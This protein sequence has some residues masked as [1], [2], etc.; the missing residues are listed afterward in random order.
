MRTL[1]AS[2]I[3]ITALSSL[4]AQYLVSEILM[5]SPGWNTVLW[6]MAGY[7]TV[8][9]NIL[10][11]A[12][13]VAAALSPGRIA[14]A[15]SAG[16]TLWICAVGVVYHLVLA[17]LWKPEGL[18]WWADQ[19]LHT[20]VPIL[21]LIWWLT[22]ANKAGLQHRHAFLWLIWPAFYCVYALARGAVSGFYPY[23]F[24]DVANLG[25]G[26][27]AVSISGLLLA[28]FVGGLGQVALSRKI[29]SV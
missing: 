21:V 17:T 12:T 28:F 18:A 6:R 19:G 29:A 5:G 13:F 2:L 23:P 11:A 10:V 14:A 25:I 26:Q 15:W 4:M 24:I 9:T 3:A 1:F 27:V 22:L 20:A 7:F 8:L 16:L